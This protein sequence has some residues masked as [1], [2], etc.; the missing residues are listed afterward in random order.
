MIFVS[1]LTL[2]KCRE[3]GRDL[4]VG[5][6]D[7]SKAFDTVDRELLW[8]ILS[9]AGCPDKFV[10]MVK[11]FHEGM[12][13][14]VQVGGLESGEFGVS[15]GVKQGCVLA[16]VLFNIFIHYVTQ[17]THTSVREGCGAHISYRI[18]RSLFNL[19]KLKARTMC[20]QSSFLEMQ[21]A[22]DCAVLG[23]SP[24]DLQEAIAV[25]SE[26]YQRFGL[27]INTNKT[28][29]L[30]YGG[31]LSADEPEIS[32]GDETLKVVRNFK[33]LGSYISDDCKLDVDI[34]SRVSQAS[35][36]FGRLRN[37]VF[38]NHHLNLSTKIRV[39]NAICLS[40][41]LYGSEAWTLYARQMRILEKWH[42]R[43]LRSILKV[44]W[45]DKVTN[46]E[47]LRRTA[48]TSLE[49]NL[50]RRQLRWLG[51]VIRM[52]SDR[53]P[54]QVLYGEL[55]DGRRSAGGQK[56]RY[57]DFIKTVLKKFNMN[58]D[59]LE[60]D[61]SNRSLW[62]RICHDGVEFFEE[63]KRVERRRRREMRHQTVTLPQPQQG[64]HTCPNCGRV[65]RSRIGLHTAQPHE[66]PPTQRRETGRRHRL[67][68]TS[69]SK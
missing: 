66:D 64:A 1:R 3:Q 25:V 65:C 53:L 9:R 60:A 30:F 19:R 44:T 55:V 6:I 11:Q 57:K 63:G 51:H 5:F 34:E 58:P 56:K 49:G 4:Y 10:K 28:E 38:D 47:V 21:Y 35:K 39:Y 12:C 41:L 52:P 40:V 33:Y 24:D 26:I 48:S 46:S 22:D 36:S 2:E 43:S 29:V 68:W 18:D 42:M 54:K 69:I 62:R 17:L 31:G 67:R 59:T 15:R 37:R 14:R 7:L 16:P 27:K 50:C 23:H 32:I 13:A 45:R 61:A 8:M 20:Q